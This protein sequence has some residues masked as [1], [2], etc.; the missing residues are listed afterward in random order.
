MDADSLHY[1][2]KEVCTKLVTV[3]RALSQAVESRCGEE[4]L[5]EHI[6]T[7]AMSALGVS[8]TIT[9]HVEARDHELREKAEL[10]EN[11]LADYDKSLRENIVA[12]VRHTRD[13]YANPLDYMTQQSLNNCLKEVAVNVKS[14]IEAARALDEIDGLGETQQGEEV[15]KAQNKASGADDTSSGSNVE[16][17]STTAEQADTIG[18]TVSEESEILIKNMD[19]I[20]D[21]IPENDADAF[22]K[23]Q[24]TIK[25]ALTS[26]NTAL[27]GIP[28]TESALNGLQDA[29]GNFLTAAKSFFKAPD[30]EAYAKRYADS[31]KDF[32]V[33]LKQLLFQ[34]TRRNRLVGRSLSRGFSKRSLTQNLRNSVMNGAANR[35]VREGSGR[36]INI[37]TTDSSDRLI[38][39]G[40]PEKSI[41]TE[42][43]PEKSTKDD[44]SSG[45][46]LSPRDATKDKPSSPRS[47]SSSTHDK[48]QVPPKPS[49]TKL[50]RS[51][52][53]SSDTSSH[54]LAT[55]TRLTKDDKQSSK[56]IVTGSDSKR[57]K[58][59]SAE[60][61]GTPRKR[62]KKE[63]S[64]EKR[65]KEK[66][67]DKKSKGDSE[68]SKD[69]RSK[70]SMASPSTGRSTLTAS[71]S[72][73]GVGNVDSS[74]LRRR[75][76][77]REDISQSEESP[78][79]TR[80]KHRRDS[81]T[82]SDSEGESR[83]GGSPASSLSLSTSGA[84]TLAPLKRE[85][86]H[87]INSSELIGEITHRQQR[88][89]EAA[90][91]PEPEIEGSII[92]DSR[93][94]DDEEEKPQVGRIRA[95]ASVS[96]GSGP[97][98][99]V[100]VVLT[101]PGTPSKRTAD[102]DKQQIANRIIQ[103][104]CER[105]PGFKTEWESA[106]TMKKV[107]T[108]NKIVS[109][110]AM[111]QINLLQTHPPIP[112][113][114]LPGSSSP[115][116]SEG[117]PRAAPHSSPS[118]APPGTQTLKMMKSS[119]KDKSKSMTSLPEKK[120]KK[121]NTPA[122]L[123]LWSEDKGSPSKD[124]PSKER[125]PRGAG[126][127]S[128]SGAGAGGAD[129]NE[130]L[131]AELQ[132]IAAMKTPAD[133]GGMTMRLK[134][135][136]RSLIGRSPSQKPGHTAIVPSAAKLPD[137]TAETSQQ[138]CASLLDFLQEVHEYSRAPATYEGSKCEELVEEEKAILTLIKGLVNSLR[139]LVGIP[140]GSASG[141]SVLSDLLNRIEDETN[142]VREGV[143][144]EVDSKLLV[145]NQYAR[146]VR[147]NLE[148]S[149]F[150]WC[151]GIY[152]TTA[153]IGTDFGALVKIV[154]MDSEVEATVMHV[155]AL[156]GA[157]FNLLTML[158]N[159]LITLNYVVVN[160]DMAR[161]VSPSPRASLSSSGTPLWN[162]PEADPTNDKDVGPFRSGTLNQ[163]I[164][165]LLAQPNDRF[166]ET[167]MDT[168]TSFISASQLL[169]KLYE[170]VMQLPN[171][172]FDK[173]KTVKILTVVCDVLGRLI[174]NGIRYD[175]D[176]H[177]TP[178]IRRLL[179]ELAKTIDI[180][181]QVQQLIVLVKNSEEEEK[182]RE[183]IY[184]DVPKEVQIFEGDSLPHAFLLSFDATTIAQQL[185]YIEFDIYKCI[186]SDELKN[187]SWNKP[188]RMCIARNVCALIQ[189]ANRISMWVATAILLQPKVK[190]RARVILKIINVAKAL[191][192]LNNYNTL[193]GIIA[194]LNMSCVSRLKQTMTTVGRKPLDTLKMLQNIVDPTS[195][196]KTLR[197]TL[198]QGGST[199][200]PYIGTTLTDLTFMED[201]N[202]D[203]F[204]HPKTHKDVIN[205]EK[206]DLL[207]NCIRSVRS[208]QTSD[209][210]ITLRDPPHTFLH[211]L[212]C[213]DEQLLYALS[214]EREPR[215]NDT[216]RKNR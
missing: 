175:F 33:A 19:I 12:L 120:P 216:F 25:T 114:M 55:P 195:S 111:Y 93:D 210:K 99:G 49:S 5:V 145:E 150:R 173:S 32:S 91:R 98:G 26:I 40:S 207:A 206:R 176:E 69:K 21:A 95:A 151:S 14:L 53:T 165:R 80:L 66:S 75:G 63:K 61:P 201:G 157:F 129:D 119:G 142:N 35:L 29:T 58:D 50:S 45:S 123:R 141:Q 78:Q 182:N 162:E 171:Q 154:E 47:N 104:F 186:T 74:P 199:Q 212:P 73:A 46:R 30:S 190:D 140:S 1:K 2:A 152:Y 112:G 194:G 16:S 208:Y 59:D 88:Q 84:N 167:F 159:D 43:S 197:E 51:A 62:D 54:D 177:C 125:S 189:R 149:I 172:K 200:L 136:F 191:R 202:P 94:E 41:S 79:V 148:R 132:R 137:S 198:R 117:S 121:T 146:L 23:A 131:D 3:C 115:T 160:T 24:N 31:Q 139:V 7:V 156:I 108:E 110:L 211:E 143:L 67:K 135:G 184:Q 22:D 124:S 209:Y 89:E 166:T 38:V 158:M 101:S 169:D 15:A 71:S 163:L 161:S 213:L 128:A 42:K 204:T 116:A 170:A 76:S 100:A 215:T 187:Q 17:P 179:G 57:T 181:I 192:E 52:T 126:N 81:T 214:L 138:F 134:G 8:S 65:D 60:S 27:E 34:V 44:S 10:Q 72:S 11:F 196:F 109:E 107:L 153:Q 86:M 183:P 6:R 205:M 168:F 18:N 103:S 28:N 77:N 193:M 96:H 122:S 82:S 144:D 92:D 180:G 68:S 133:L 102:N 20:S 4:A 178:K 118:A 127:S 130:Q 13:F 164:V 203:S 185:T 90:N 174:R 9:A 64:K 147:D 70:G 155:L 97:A 105:F 113:S 39:S 85:S 37:T 106:D 83:D 188:K 56:V 87:R 36:T 48:P